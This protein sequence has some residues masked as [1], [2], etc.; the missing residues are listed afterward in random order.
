MKQC[1]K[2]FGESFSADA[3]KAAN[4]ELK[5]DVLQITNHRMSRCPRH[6]LSSL[7][8]LMTLEEIQ[9]LYHGAK[10]KN[11]TSCLS[12]NASQAERENVLTWLQIEFANAIK[13]NPNYHSPFKKSAKE[14]LKEIELAII[15]V[16]HLKVIPEFI[17]NLSDLNNVYEVILE[18]VVNKKEARKLI[19]YIE[20]A[21]SGKVEEIDKIKNNTDAKK[22]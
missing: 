19:A 12:T 6:E 5:A 3:L 13:S 2:Q 4:E 22:R 10:N 1:K 14:E 17:V 21:R 9:S 8:Y 16:K 15:C 18:N 20:V 11:F 7:T